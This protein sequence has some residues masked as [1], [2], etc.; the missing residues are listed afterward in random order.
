PQWLAP[1]VPHCLLAFLIF[2]L[3]AQTIRSLKVY[4]GIRIKAGNSGA[5]YA[6]YFLLLA[7]FSA[8]FLLKT[9]GIHE[10]G[11]DE[12]IYYYG[13]V[14]MSKGVLPYRDFFFAHPPVHLVIPAILF[15][16]IPFNI[17][18]AKMIPLAAFLASGAFLYLTVREKA[19]WIKAILALAA[20][21]SCYEVLMAS[22]DMTGINLTTMFCMISLYLFAR[23]SYSASGILSGVALMTGLYSA[24]FVL[25]LFLFA[26]FISRSSLLSFL[27]GLTGAF[28][29][30]FLI[31]LFIGG[32]GFLEGVFEYHTKKPLKQEGQ[33][34]L[35]SPP[36][37]AQFIK[38]LVNNV[39]VFAASKK[40][41]N[42]LYFHAPYYVAAAI[43]FLTVL[44]GTALKGIRGLNPLKIAE[45]PY[46]TEKFAILCALL[47]IVQFSL[48]REVYDFY[49]TIMMPLLSILLGSVL[50]QIYDSAVSIAGSLRGEEGASSIGSKAL[51]LA[52]SLLVFLWLPL[53]SRVNATFPEEVSGKG[54]KVEYR[55]KN[56]AYPEFLSPLVKYLYFSD[57]RIRGEVEPYWRH[58][59]WNKSL[60]FSKAKEI[61]EYIKE[62]SDENET[63]TGAS[64]LAPLIALYADRR[65]A[66]NEVDTNAKRFKS[67]MITDVEFFG[68]VCAD[69]LKFLVSAPMSY[70]EP[71]RMAKDPYIQQ[72]F[73]LEKEFK[74]PDLKHFMEFPILIYRSKGTWG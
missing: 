13:A 61:A 33:M 42:S 26:L 57:S 10:S 68:R 54:E 15:A 36:T 1:P 49:L 21:F 51:L 63:I 47:F 59:V 18:A 23:K 67:G 20:F 56:A 35:F 74:D 28:F 72:H 73:V 53:A 52:M 9:A 37:L 45:S 34:P 8:A 41:M 30:V 16:V 14:L 60:V 19:G 43:G 29:A 62:N 38:A 64:T 58:Y 3:I 7:V 44:A 66:A 12:N 40:F 65:L 11:T 39:S 24:A 6:E 27:A 22:T 55:W 70:F 46:F 31:F 4:K 17:V 32:E 25:A 71:Q 69:N 5:K 48:L 2:A 50:Y